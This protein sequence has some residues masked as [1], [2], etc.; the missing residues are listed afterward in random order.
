MV[1]G[2]GRRPNLELRRMVLHYHLIGYDPAMIADK[3]AEL[4][5]RRYSVSYI[6]K[7]LWLMKKEGLLA[8]P[9]AGN[10]WADL[11]IWI[12][13]SKT[14]AYSALEAVKVR[15]LKTAIEELKTVLDYLERAQRCYMALYVGFSGARVVR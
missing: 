7:L 9:P 4:T 1:A 10:L 11:E 6:R 5:G 8:K 14:H 3:V 13:A 12:R 15:D 2:V